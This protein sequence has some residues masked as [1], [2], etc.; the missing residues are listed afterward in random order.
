VLAYLF[1]HIVPNVTPTEGSRKGLVDDLRRVGE[2]ESRRRMRL[3]T[4]ATAAL[5]IPVPVP[6]PVPATALSTIADRA[7]SFA[8]ARA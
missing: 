1:H 3:A 6:V 4:T 8:A 5:I 7:F 2:V